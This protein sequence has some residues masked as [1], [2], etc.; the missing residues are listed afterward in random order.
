MSKLVIELQKACLSEHISV[1]DLL[2]KARFTAKKLNKIEMIDFCTKELEGYPNEVPD[3]RYISVTY[4]AYNPVR[5]EWIPVEIPNEPPISNFLTRPVNMSVGEMTSF[6]NGEENLL[7]MEVPQSMRDTIYYHLNSVYDFEI[8]SF[9]SSSKFAKIL[10]AVKKRIT[11]WTLDLEKE[12]ILGDDF[13][14]ETIEQENA[15]QMT[16]NINGSVTGSNVVGHMEQSSAT[17]NNNNGFDFEALKKL[18]TKIE[19]DLENAKNI[20][21]EKTD[22]LKE[23][24]ASLKKSVEEQNETSAMDLL[25]NIATGAISSGIWSI[26]STITT[27]LSSMA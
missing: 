23:Q 16:I 24:I 9:F 11:D 12:G 15:K 3:Y 25:K 7:S 14:F 2:H 27:F 20:E 5:R 6:L 22:S 13:E 17:I 1:V 26:G 4:K 8:K 10:N 21:A 19:T 18:I